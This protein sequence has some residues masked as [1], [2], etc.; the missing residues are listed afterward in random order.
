MKFPVG[1]TGL[2]LILLALVVIS[3]SALGHRYL[4]TG[5]TEGR[6]DP[7][8]VKD[9][10]ISWAAYSSLTKKNDVDYYRFDATAGEE[11]YASILVP[12]IKRLKGFSPDLA[13]IGP[14]IDELQKDLRAPEQN[15]DLREGE[16]LLLDRYSGDK[17]EVF[18]EPFTQTSYWERQELRLK[19]PQTGAYFLAVFHPDDRTGKYVLA[20]G[21][22][23]VFGVG[24]ILGL[25]GTW[26]RVSKFAEKKLSTYLI[27]A[28]VLG[29]IVAG[30]YFLVRTLF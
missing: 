25:P 30:S 9:H 6:D 1:T 19:A 21:E 14:G 5:G 24:D 20:I 27:T 23:E 16:G 28:G 18:F 13:L 4:K 11:I 2:F 8:V 10:Q 7:V 29:G 12:K 26:W 22:R 3:P 15:L 17:D